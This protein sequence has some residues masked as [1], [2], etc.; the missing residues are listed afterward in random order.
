MGF[1]LLHLPGAWQ[2]AW[3]GLVRLTRCH[4]A[5]D[6]W[7]GWGNLN[8][9]VT[10]KRVMSRAACCFLPLWTITP[11]HFQFTPHRS[12][13][14]AT[15]VFTLNYIYIFFIL[16]IFLLKNENC[17]I[18][19]FLQ[20]DLSYKLFC[21][22]L[23]KTHAM[24]NFGG[25]GRRECATRWVLDLSVLG[26]AWEKCADKVVGIRSKRLEIL[27][28]AHQHLLPKNNHH[29]ANKGGLNASFHKSKNRKIQLCAAVPIYRLLHH[30]GQ[31]MHCTASDLWLC[32]CSRI[33]AVWGRTRFALYLI[34]T[35]IF[36]NDM[37][38]CRYK[39]TQSSYCTTCWNINY[40]VNNWN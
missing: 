30:N 39:Q 3:A 4:S 13:S 22:W 24:E 36:A 27:V 32:F 25:G 35:W 5:R 2:H 26:D 19:Y 38:C 16:E 37:L 15:I 7:R 34:I 9:P 11:L 6:H 20:V 23:N 29:H 17:I 21:K 40:F 31:K 10:G 28:F 14:T 1:L 18:S 12:K 33:E 8:T